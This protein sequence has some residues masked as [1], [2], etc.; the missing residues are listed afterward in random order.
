MASAGTGA[1]SVYLDDTVR[2]G[3][4]ALQPA[5]QAFHA[6][7][8]QCSSQCILSA[9]SLARGG[10]LRLHYMDLPLE[11]LGG[12]LQQVV[13]TNTKRM[14]NL[15]AYISLTVRCIQSD[16]ESNLQLPTRLINNISE[17]LA[18]KREGSLV[19]NLY[20]L[21][22]TGTFTP[23]TLEWLADTVK[24]NTHK[25]W[26]KAIN[27]LYTHVRTHL[28][29]HL[30]PALDRLAIAANAIRGHALL[31]EHT[32]RFVPSE[33]FTTL[34]DDIDSIRLLAQHLQ[35]IIMTEHKQF[36]AFSKWLRVTIDIGV[37]GP[38]SKAAAEI[39]EREVPNLDE[40]LVLAYIKDTLSESRLASHLRSG[41]PVLD[42]TAD[43]DREMVV[44]ALR[45][46]QTPAKTA[47]IAAIS[48][49][50]LPTL[51][52]RLESRT[53]EVISSISKWQSRMLPEPSSMLLDSS[54]A[55]GPHSIPS[56]F[57][58]KIS[59]SRENDDTS[60]TATD[61]LMAS[62]AKEGTSQVSL[63]RSRRYSDN[64]TD[65]F[66]ATCTLDEV[67]LLDARIFRGQTCLVLV[68]HQDRG[69][70]SLLSYDFNLENEQTSRSRVIHGFDTESGFNPGHFVIGGR[71]GK[72]VCVAFD[73]CGREWK[74][75]DLEDCMN[76][77]TIDE[78]RR[79]GTIGDILTVTAT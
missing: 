42:L 58:L 18:E 30:I 79:F 61:V 66:H 67:Q 64:T 24:E 22:M 12:S 35:L 41:S 56:V 52:T 51:V 4:F 20:H 13:S 6:S 71:R 32:Y 70:T 60:C 5:A 47:G 34:M 19:T 37:A 36:K 1:T 8:P 27:D 68:K 59:P 62:R 74:V 7:H 40:G 14:Q 28:F 10:E 77:E 9:S 65:A 15:V 63:C 48:L 29:V 11:A 78:R 26:D 54:T 31:H 25:R 16:F 50:N 75:L 55:F 3:G 69:N 21:A 33:P 45:E 43:G 2:I 73:T 53:R 49:L 38:G 72:M 17:E 39:E 23:T 76:N 57:D 46:L 44:K